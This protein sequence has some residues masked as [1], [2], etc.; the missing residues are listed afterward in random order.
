MKGV[1]DRSVLAHP[2]FTGVSRAHLALLAEELA[3]PWTAAAE[4]RRFEA[5]GGARK[6]AAG[7]GAR[8]QLVFVDRL[9]ATLIHLR[10]DLPHAVLAVLFGVDRSTVTRG[11]GE[12]RGLLARRGCAVPDRPGLRLRTL[13][14][15]FAYAQTENIELRLDATEVQVRRPVAG[16]GGRRAFVSG[17]KK[18]NTMKATVVADG[19]GRTLWTDTLRPGRMHDVTAARAG[20]IASCFEHFA[21]VEVLLDDGYLGLGRDHPGQAVTPPRRPRPGALPGRF[22]QWERDRHG[23]AADRITVEHALAHHKRWKQLI[24]WTHRRDRLPDTYR[25]IASLV[26]DRSSMT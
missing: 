16:R 7:A 20:G 10:H 13:E 14:D 19:R 25:A 21:R 26:S 12:V 9:V 22:E 8:Y 1:I 17:K 23:H 5:R 2:L 3:G 11:L 18:Q 15:V 6:R 4:G 24:R